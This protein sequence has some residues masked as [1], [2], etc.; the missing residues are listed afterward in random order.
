VPRPGRHP[1]GRGNPGHAPREEVERRLDRDVI[2]DVPI[3]FTGESE[4]GWGRAAARTARA[5]AHCAD[6][7]RRR[8][9]DLIAGLCPRPGVTVRIGH[10][11]TGLQAAAA[12]ATRWPDPPR[13]R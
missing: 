5:D 3:R 7:A 6:R 9:A 11:R 4:P 1:D 12:S 10:D 8:A 13:W 2:R